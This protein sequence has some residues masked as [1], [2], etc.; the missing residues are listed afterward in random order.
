MR[1]T[2]HIDP[3]WDEI[4]MQRIKN[5]MCKYL[6]CDIDSQRAQE[7]EKFLKEELKQ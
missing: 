7:V 4:D 5:I 2:H 1:T 3:L 6:K